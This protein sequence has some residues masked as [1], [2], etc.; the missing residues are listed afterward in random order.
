VSADVGLRAIAIDIDGT[1]IDSRK[2][3]MAFTRS[4]IERVVSEYQAHL[5]LITARGPQ[6]TAVIEERLGVRAS[7]ATFGGSLVEVRESDGSFLRLKQEPL[8]DIDVRGLIEIARDFDVHIGLY[9]HDTWYVNSLEYWGMREARNTAIWPELVELEQ[10]I[11]RQANDPLFKIMFRG[12]S[13]PLIRLGSALR[14]IETSTY[15]HQVKHVIEIVASGAVKLPALTEITDYL[16][17]GL[18]QVIAFGDTDADLGMLAGV[19]VGYLMGNA[20]SELRVAPNVLRALSNDEDG[21]GVAL[22]K[23]FPSDAPFRP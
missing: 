5:I 20:N 17:I 11:D 16:G 21:I 13:E 3:I 22:R 10:V 18:D 8:L 1:L 9:T 15:I 14:E 12:E 6:S 7:F 23:H 4:E 19:G 2:R